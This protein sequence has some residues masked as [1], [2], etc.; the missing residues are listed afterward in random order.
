LIESGAVANARDTAAVA[1]ANLELVRSICTARERGDYGSADWAD[2]EIEYVLADGPTPGT[3]RGLDEMAQGVRDFLGAWADFRAIAEDCRELDD[4]RVLVL[5]TLQGRGK[6]SGLDL[7][8][9]HTKGADV[10][11][12]RN[13]KV[14][15]IVHYFDRQRALADLGLAPEVD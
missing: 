11:H 13:G 2:P 1:S 12:L 3:W 10:F 8:Q 15:R 9:T 14:T 7:D 5:L 6:T 4:H